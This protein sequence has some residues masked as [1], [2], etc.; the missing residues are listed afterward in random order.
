MSR[1]VKSIY[2]LL[3]LLPSRLKKIKCLQPY[4]DAKCDACS[5]AKVSCRFRDRE[6]YFVERS[7]AIA[8][9]SARAPFG[10]IQTTS[11]HSSGRLSGSPHDEFLDPL[12]DQSLKAFTTH[13]GGGV[14]YSG[15]PPMY[16]HC[17][18]SLINYI[19]HSRP[20]TYPSGS[21]RSSSS[22]SR[23]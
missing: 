4:P 1:D 2:S 6:R 15:R 18:I 13:Q 8:G 20:Q 11:S 9:P 12:D 16:L 14:P 19:V 3:K 23:R 21:V 17:T 22:K 10:D 5:Q 7:R